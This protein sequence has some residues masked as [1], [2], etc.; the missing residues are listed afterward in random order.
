VVEHVPPDPVAALKMLERLD[1]E[2][3]KERKE[4]ETT[5]EFSLKRLLYLSMA[6]REEAARLAAKQANV[7]EGTVAK[8]TEE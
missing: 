4:I 7:I 2:T 5:G 6:D 3:W 1:P 8:E